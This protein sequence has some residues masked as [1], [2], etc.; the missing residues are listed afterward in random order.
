[1]KFL[2]AENLNGIGEL[3]K[4]S[5]VEAGL[6]TDLPK[7]M[8]LIT[9]SLATNGVIIADDLDNPTC[10]A[11]ATIGTTIVTLETILAINIIFTKESA[12]GQGLGAKM[13]EK[14]KTYAEIKGAKA[15]Y[16]SAR[17]PEAKLFW[18][19]HQPTPD[20]THYRLEI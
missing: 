10:Y 12:R 17:T 1:M 15:L 19:K 6:E 13:V 18:E 8:A 14:L 3:V 4:A 9:G 11:W 5:A 20:E 7:L 2:K 16:G